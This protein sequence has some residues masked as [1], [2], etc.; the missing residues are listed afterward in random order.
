MLG[1]GSE[2]QREGSGVLGGGKWGQRGRE[3]GAWGEGS[4]DWIPPCLPPQNTQ[5]NRERSLLSM[6]SALYSDL[7]QFEKY[8]KTQLIPAMKKPLN[9]CGSTA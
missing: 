7:H 3:V 2:A 8:L 4:G 1:E 9:R 5:R 6:E